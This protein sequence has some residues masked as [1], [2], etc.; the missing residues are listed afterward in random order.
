MNHK[1]LLLFVAFLLCLNVAYGQRFY[2][3]CD[4]KTVVE[5]S[6]VQVDFILEN[7]DG[8]KFGPPNFRG[9][10]VVSGPSTS[11]STSITNGN[12]SKTFKVSYGLQPKAVGTFTI[13]SAT[14]LVNGK[15]Q[16]TK[17]LQLKV[18]KGSDK[19][20]SADKQ[21]YV[22]AVLSDS[23]AYVGQQLLLTYVLYTTL[24]VK[25][26]DVRTEG[27]FDG[28]FTEQLRLGKINFTREIIDGVEYYTR[29]LWKAA[30]FPQQTGTYEIPETVVELGIAKPGARRSFFSSF[31]VTPRIVR[32]EAIKIQ[33]KGLPPTT[34]PYTGAVGRYR[35][36]ATTSKKTLTTD[37][38]IEVRVEILGNGDAKTVAAPRWTLPEG[39]E[40][41]D[42]NVLDDQIK[43][44]N[45]GVNHSKIFEYLIV[46][47]RAGKYNLQ[48]TFTFFDTDKNEYVT[49]RKNLGTV[50]VVQGSNKTPQVA[51]VERQPL[52][53]IFATTTLVQPSPS[54]Y[55]SW[56]HLLG[57]ALCFLGGLGLFLY[58]N[59]LKKSGQLDPAHLRKDKAK[60]VAQNQLKQSKLFL[61]KEDSKGFHQ[62]MITALKTY[63][64][65]KYSIPALHIKKTELLQKLTDTN[66]TTSDI[67]TFKT[68][69]DR[70]EIAMYAPGLA[71]EMT[72]TYNKAIDLIMGLE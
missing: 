16:K 47:K 7:L 65:D 49:L 55:N 34:E 8:S 59:Y 26:F 42:P 17:P 5:G 72:D 22:K 56:P 9:F 30:L 63:V 11:T 25:Q 68:I 57:L 69:L 4:A 46:A 53:G 50:T 51:A 29:P 43:P 10:D 60:E 31:Q 27:D 52:A 71:T 24:D 33:V 6:Y 67:E 62:E 28:F 23:T 18:V 20:V 41:Y 44:T 61:D 64:T 36:S 40:M 37:D 12:I 58:S 19:S 13:G 21:V 66:M 3:S 15:T 14:V 2:A 54:F 48:P 35:M 45:Q 32:A 38:A 39:L 1:S 70:S